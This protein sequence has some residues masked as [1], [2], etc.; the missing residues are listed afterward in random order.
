MVNGEL[1]TMSGSS[2]LDPDNAPILPDQPSGKGPG[3]GNDALGPSDTSDSG[4]D[5]Q[6]GVTRTSKRR[7]QVRV[8]L[9][10]AGQ[11]DGLPAAESSDTDSRGTGERASVEPDGENAD[12]ADVDVDRIETFKKDG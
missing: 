11:L 7:S 1:R 8:P 10:D 3:H 9:T 12:G 5:V 2:T 6:G 4:S